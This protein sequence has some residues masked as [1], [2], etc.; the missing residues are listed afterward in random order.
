VLLTDDPQAHRY[1]LKPVVTMEPE[2]DRCVE[3]GYC[4]PVC[5]SRDLTTTP[6][7]RI[8]LRREIAGARA[9]GNTELAQQLEQQYRYD[10]V[11]TCAVDGMC[12]TACPVLINTGDLTNASVPRTTDV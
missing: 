3:C 8:V 4:E 12:A 2:V 11:D 7:Q 1:H 5:P 6:R 9:A 10:A